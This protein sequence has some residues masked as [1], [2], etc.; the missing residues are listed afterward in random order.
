MNP[1]SSTRE[2]L[3]ACFYI[4]DIDGS[5]TLELNELKYYFRAIIRASLGRTSH[6]Y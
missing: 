4:C 2:K 6:N 5:N 1:I 3:A